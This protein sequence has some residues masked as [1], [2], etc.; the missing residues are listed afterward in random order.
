MMKSE[1]THEENQ[2]SNLSYINIIGKEWIT[3]PK[4]MTGKKLR[5]ITPKLL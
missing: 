4:K 5:K 1:K 2:K 3:H